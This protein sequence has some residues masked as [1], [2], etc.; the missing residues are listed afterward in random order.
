MSDANTAPAE[1]KPNLLPI[2]HKLGP[3]PISDKEAAELAATGDENA[4]VYESIDTL[5]TLARMVAALPMEQRREAAQRIGLDQLAY[6]E[7]LFRA[8]YLARS[9]ER[10]RTTLERDTRDHDEFTLA[11]ERRVTINAYDLNDRRRGIILRIEDDGAGPTLK[12]FIQLVDVRGFVMTSDEPAAT[13]ELKYD[14]VA[15]EEKLNDLLVETIK[16]G[17]GKA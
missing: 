11:G 5:V 1:Q 7:V 16:A 6:N 15:S 9:H 8:D 10:G 17:D 4:R 2:M 14:Q 3:R 13:L 12:A